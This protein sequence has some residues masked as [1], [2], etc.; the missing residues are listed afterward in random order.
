MEPLDLFNDENYLKLLDLS[1][2]VAQSLKGKLVS[3][4]RMADCQQLAIKILY[5]ATTLWHLRHGTK[6]PVPLST[7]G[8]FFFDFA[9]GAVVTRA[10]IE[11]FLTLHEVFFASCTEDER[12]LRYRVW[13]LSGFAIRDNLIPSDPDLQKLYADSQIDLAELRSQIQKTQ[14]FSALPSGKKRRVLK[15][16]RLNRDFKSRLI[17]AGFGPTWGYRIYKFYSGYAH[18]DAL[19]GAQIQ[20]AATKAAQLEHIQLQMG[21]VMMILSRMIIEYAKAFPDANAA[22]EARP[23]ALGLANILS[24]FVSQVPQ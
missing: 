14:A 6:A 5:H 22:A 1:Y 19:S 16:E 17:D 8:S 4:G 18:S 24:Y 13:Q 20:I 9:S 7:C 2:E 23:Q 12:E 21:I 11:A 15:G 3:D 10:T